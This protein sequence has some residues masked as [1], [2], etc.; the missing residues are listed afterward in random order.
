MVMA[1]MTR[2]S[3][4]R[5]ALDVFD[6]E[7]HAAA[8]Q[9]GRVDRPARAVDR[10]PAGHAGLH[11]VAVGVFGD[12]LGALRLAGLHADGVRARADQRH[13]A[14]QHVEELRQLVEAGAADEAA[15]AGDARRRR[16][17]PAA[18]AGASAAV[19]RIERNFQTRISSLLKPWRRWRK[20]TG[21]GLSSLMASAISAISG[22][23]EQ[24][25][26]A[27]PTTR[28]CGALHQ[29]P[30]LVAGRAGDRRQRR[31]G[32]PRQR[33]GA[34][35]RPLV[36]EQHHLVGQHRQP[37]DQLAHPGLGVLRHRDHHAVDVGHDPVR[38]AAPRCRP[39][40][41]R[42]RRRGRRAADAV[43][44]HAQH[45]GLAASQRRADQP[46]GVLV[47]ADHDD[48][49]RQPAL[50]APAAHH[51][52]PQGVQARRAPRSWPRTRARRPR[53]SRSPVGWKPTSR[54]SRHSAARPKPAAT[55]HQ[56]PAEP[57]AL[58]KGVGVDGREAP[59]QRQRADD[60]R[61][62]RGGR[63]AAGR[64]RRGGERERCPARRRRRC[65]RSRPASSRSAASGS[66][67]APPVASARAGRARLSRAAAAWPSW[68]GALRRR[69]QA[70]RR[71]QAF[72]PGTIPPRD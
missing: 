65:G 11:A 60:E 54:N 32:D 9:L 63:D 49:G 43:V 4:Q 12:Q 56:M 51:R 29:R 20:N 17:A 19:G 27:T 62:E 7:R 55:L 71:A 70:R 24:R 42:R 1:M 46:L 6:V 33:R 72:R 68:P 53:Q 45:R 44:E 39:A 61:R 8:H 38:R 67:S 66:A 26:P 2:S 41:A 69:L 14:L 35:G 37:L 16:R 31:L 59:D 52:P 18:R 57:L 47:G 5:L 25:A 30:A 23:A 36:D 50:G 48:V 34:A 13:L 10:R 22:S 28:S 40:P 64:Q 3:Q 58:R 21:P 15:D